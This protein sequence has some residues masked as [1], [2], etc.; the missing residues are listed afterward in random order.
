[1]FHKQKI[2][3]IFFFAF[4]WFNGFVLAQHVKRIETGAGLIRGTI[5]VFE[6]DSLGYF[7]IG[8]DKGLNRYSGL[9]FKNYDL[10]SLS[11]VESTGIIDMLNLNGDL[12]MISPNGYLITYDYEHD[13]FEQVL[14]IDQ[15]R[16]LSMAQLDEDRILIGLDHGYIIYNLTTQKASDILFPE[17]FINRGIQVSN[18]VVYVA[19]GKG[20][21]I[22]DVLPD[23]DNLSLREV[24]LEKNDIIS[25][26]MDSK[27]RLWIG[28]E[29]GGLFIRDEKEIRSVFIKEL[30]KKTYAIRKIEFDTQNNAL[31][32]IDRLGLFVFDENLNVINLFGHNIDNPNSIGQNSIYEVYVDKSNA[33]WLGLREGGINIIYNNDNIFNQIHHVQN[34][35]NSINNNTIRA[36]YESADGA[37]WF[38]T[39][40]GIS[41]Y[42]NQKVQNYNSHPKLFNTAVLSIAAYNGDLLLG[43][44]G[45]GILVF[46]RNNGVIDKPPFNKEVPLKLVF[47]ISVFNDDIWIAQGNDG[48]LLHFTKNQLVHTYDVGLVRSMVQGYDDIIYAGSN[49]GFFEINKRN[50]S[51]RKIREDTFNNLNEIHNLNFDQLN[52]A[53]WLGSA[54][55][56]HKFN[57]SNEVLDHISVNTNKEIGTVFS[58]KKDNVQNLYLAA[59]TGLWR[60]DIKT[61]LFRKYSD[62]DGLDIQEFGP[63]ASAILRD[64]RLAFGGPEG[65][66]VFQPIDLERDPEISKIYLGNFQINGKQPDSLTLDRNINYT[67]DIVLGYDQNTISF[68]FETIKFHGSKRNRFEWQLRGYDDSLRNA[69]G[70]E[71]IT[72]SNLNPGDY[73]LIAT[74]FNAD[75]EKAKSDYLLNI[76]IKKPFWKS[77]IALTSYF[78]ILCFFIFLVYRINIANIRKRSD[79]DRIKFFVEVAH[80]IRTPVSLIQLLVKQLANQEQVEKSMELIQRNTQNLNEYVSQLLDFQ[81]LDR[82]QLKLQ[83]SQVNLKACLSKIVDDFTPIL[84]EKSID[85]ILKVKH[86]P[87]WFDV[88]KMSRIFYNLIS[89]AIKYSNEGSE[90]TISAFLNDKTLRIDFIDNGIGIPEKQQNAI[91]NRFTRGTNVANQGIP[92]TGIGLMLS[93][94]I[95]E[96]HG[97]KITLE[98][99]ENIGS[100]F[101]ILLPG[102]SEHYG[103][104]VL[105]HD[106]D[107]PEKKDKLEGLLI[108]EKLILLVEDNIELR[109]AIKNELGKVHAIIEASN[110]KEG[111]LL[112]LSK[113]P[114][115]IITDVMMPEMDGKELCHLLK[116]NFKTSHIPII[117]LTAL[118]DIDDK[119]KGLETGADAYVEKPFNVSILNATINNLIRSREN[120]SRLLDDKKIDKHLTPDERFLSDVIETIRENLTEKDFSIDKLAEMM[121]LS[122]SNL[123]RKLKGLVQMSP[124]DLILK[125]KLNHAE[126]LMKKKSHS[127]ISDIAYESGFHDPKHFSTLFKKY[128]EKTPKEYIDS[129]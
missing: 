64:G 39:E 15:K 103:E 63:G 36:I 129:L 34:D 44:Y 112:A 85:V 77:G 87:V 67:R 105:I 102:G 49:I 76:K 21:Y 86:I 38:G 69:Y 93:K 6:K 84:K 75:G 111:L 7:W 78:L 41:K 32:A 58:I 107:K 98:S 79:E 56:L 109:S 108:K 119:I 120:I 82:N 118:A 74:G 113:S 126:E 33:Y 70:D 10:K 117:M 43:T 73:R 57:L 110:G 19:T 114:D 30:Q 97:G 1:M 5:N 25:I 88:P 71:K 68:N 45:E 128:Y 54:K 92:G 83:V 61:K 3:V 91:F 35:A 101:T 59:T 13:R 89:N 31:V 9:E 23:S 40:S 18:N 80:D 94:K 106:Y 50:K 22:F 51:V 24:I 11:S 2:G 8:S 47:N 125:I 42:E 12:Y 46:D 60:Y 37:L 48:P 124:S 72:Y 96:L 17:T 116:T 20:C 99:K 95:I 52:N 115:L 29:V 127:R 65:A 66:V 62:Q 14:H 28:T 4:I 104:D 122:R 121:G 100:K 123:F 53:I 26:A 16:F 81:K 55:G 90:I 27:R